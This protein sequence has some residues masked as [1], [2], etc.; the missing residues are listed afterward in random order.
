[1]LKRLG[2]IF[3]NIIT[4]FAYFGCALI[5]FIVLSVT[6]E[7]FTRFFL[8]RS[9]VWVTEID[10]YAMIAFTFFAAAWVLK[11][12]GH[13]VLDVVINRFKPKNKAA[14]NTITSILSA[15]ACGAICWYGASNL[16]YHIQE[17]TLI[18]E[19]TIDMPKAPMLIFIPLGFF[20]F[21]I[22]FLRRA[23]GFLRVWRGAPPVAEEEKLVEEIFESF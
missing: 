6:A 9:L 20:L 22:Q 5:A 16:W 4:Y 17:G 1:M 11:R 12:E 7:V 23:Y 2:I 14:A 10:E 13:V 18:V 8:N 21:A 3:D 15:I 19:K